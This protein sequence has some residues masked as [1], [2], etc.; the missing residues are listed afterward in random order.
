M[1]W[2]RRLLGSL[3]SLPCDFYDKMWYIL[4][5][6]PEGIRL[7][8]YHLPQ[9]PTLSDLTVQEMRFSLL[10]EEMLAVIRDPIHRQ[11][12]VEVGTMRSMILHCKSAEHVALLLLM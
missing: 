2:K 5:R 7:Y 12:V 6:T 3:G 1:L 4:Q 8:S 9:Q 11:M 10:I